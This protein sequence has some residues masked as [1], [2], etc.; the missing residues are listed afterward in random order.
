METPD[1]IPRMPLVGGN[2]ALDYINTRGGQ[3]RPPADDETLQDYNHLVAWAWHA[4]ILTEAE[5]HRLRR[6]A[7]RNPD[8]AQHTY[9]R[10][11]QLRSSLY[12]LFTAVAI[13]QPPPGR[14]LTALRSEE[15]E[16]LTRA[17]LVGDDGGF[18]WSWAH[19]KELGRPLWPI[20]HAAVALL[21]A[22]PLQRV[23]RCD[24]CQWLFIDESKNRSRR[25]CSMQDC[26]TDQKIRR[27]L[28]RRTAARR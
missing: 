1:H 12:E 4:G 8:D 9:Q 6:Q 25:W 2:L 21:T 20:M 3:P 14:C 22:G 23:K 13:G 26:G 16:A 19:D 17:D 15:A 24:G 10:A 18:A 28:A 27:Y 11:V 5:A 7:R